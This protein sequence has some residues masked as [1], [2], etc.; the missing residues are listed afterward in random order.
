MIGAGKARTQDVDQYRYL[1]HARQDDFR[2]VGDEV[3]TTSTSWSTHSP[4]W[5]PARTP[6]DRRWRPSACPTAPAK[7]VDDLRDPLELALEDSGFLHIGRGQHP[8]G[9]DARELASD[10]LAQRVEDVDDA[11]AKL[12]RDFLRKVWETKQ[13]ISATLM[14]RPS[15]AL[16]TLRA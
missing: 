14:P 3:G 10:P 4:P 16:S 7:R 1:G 13:G 15:M 8:D 2:A 5:W 11:D 6:A 12:R 9:L